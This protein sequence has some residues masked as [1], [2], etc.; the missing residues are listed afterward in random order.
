MTHSTG[1]LR[2]EAGYVMS[3]TALMLLPLIAFVALAIDVGGWTVQA[4]QAQNAADAA[5][6]AGAA[7][8]P[9]QNAADDV[10]REV[11]ELNGYEHNVD[12]ATV[13]VTFPSIS[14][15]RVLV[16]RGA[17]RYFSQIVS[18]D[19]FEIARYA[20]ATSL[21][22]V[23]MGSPT[24]VLGFGPYSL[25][26]TQPA[27]YWILE[28]NDCQIAHYGDVAAAK[29]LSSPW[30][31][32]GLGLDLNPNWKRASD[33]RDGGYFYVV[34]IPPGV[35]VPSTLM[36]FD[37]GKCG[38]YGLKPG[39]TR[40]N[41]PDNEGTLLEWRQWS[42]NNTPLITSDDTAVS[43]WWGSDECANDLPYPA[44][45][46]TDQTE[47]WTT[48][49]FTFPANTTGETETHLIQ[50]RVLDSTRLGWNYHA[51]WVRPNNGTEGCS[52][53][54]STSCPTIGAESWFATGAR[55]SANGVPMELFLAEVGPEHEGR[56]MNVNLW[57]P[58]EGMDNIQVIDPL[59]NSLDFTW[60]S[61]D[62]NHGIG[63]A[64]DTCAGNPCLYLDPFGSSYAAK[65]SNPGWNAHW[66]FN[67]R[68][69][70]LSVPLDQ[71][72]DYP[73]YATSGLGYWFR[74]RFEP[75]PTKVATEWASFGVQVSGD[76]I[77]LTD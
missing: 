18:D 77:R 52:S 10:A 20:D 45:S 15:I 19:A 55:G 23:T 2:S 69:I 59:G 38:A 46:W 7:L 6:L 22:P 5:A 11:A 74:I 26:G 40:H 3:I 67:G 33:G 54:G 63:N 13:E 30:C 50:S 1:D 29:Y 35:T 16:S 73:A 60:S 25:D 17:D 57:D 24:N 28:N 61:D 49:P 58:G 70:S 4:T 65:L 8:L 32:D 71:Q 42:T 31:G 64:S 76:P 36:V 68:Q 9:D 62:P 34:E 47:G 37:P 41:R 14:T 56:V 66:R 39:D 75:L 72:V 12:G 21:S 27:N 44:T 43:G 51:F 53:I 48:T